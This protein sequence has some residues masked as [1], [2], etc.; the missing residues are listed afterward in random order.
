M[1]PPIQD[2]PGYRLCYVEMPHV[3][4]FDKFDEHGNPTVKGAVESSV[5]LAVETVFWGHDWNHT[6]VRENEWSHKA[7]DGSLGGCAGSLDR[8]ESDIALMMSEYRTDN[9]DTV[10][11]YALYFEEPLVITTVYYMTNATFKSDILLTSLKSFS[12]SLWI[13]VILTILGVKFLNLVVRLANKIMITNTPQKSLFQHFTMI[14]KHKNIGTNPSLALVMATSI[15]MFVIINYYCNLISTEMV[16][17]QKPFMLDDFEKVMKNNSKPTFLSIS[18]TY[19]V[20]KESPPGTLKRRVWNQ[21]A[22]LENNRDIFIELT[23]LQSIADRMHGILTTERV[24]VALQLYSILLIAVSCQMR[25]ARPNGDQM[26]MLNT[27]MF[28]EEKYKLGPLR[29]SRLKYTN[30]GKYMKGQTG[31]IIEG[32]LL[33]IARKDF[34]YGVDY[35]PKLKEDDRRECS[36]GTYEDPDVNIV[37]VSL[38]NFEFLWLISFIGLMAASLVFAAEFLV[39]KFGVT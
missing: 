23:D 7:D 6:L 13:M 18:D 1:T 30:Y 35:A 36:K 31:R 12:A 27:V 19:R 32:G 33:A 4:E 14:F 22:H 8:N 21:Y 9:Y 34:S 11:P 29:N 16:I 5:R 37:A 3:V 25:D 17:P 10:E 15:G 26:R 24:I 20:F 39:K 2:E 28:P 38:K